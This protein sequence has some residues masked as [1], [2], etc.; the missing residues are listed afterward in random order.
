MEESKAHDIKDYSVEKTFIIKNRFGLHARAASQ[1]VKLANKFDSEIFIG[2][3][4][5]EVNGKSIM[6][7]LILAAGCGAEITVRASGGGDAKEAL[8][9]LG[10]LIEQGFGEE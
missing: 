4:G 10:D 8:A 1:F 6:G 5:Q 2:K 7:I 3:G 9:A